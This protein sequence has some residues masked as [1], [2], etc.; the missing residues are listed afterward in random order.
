MTEEGF[1][2]TELCLSI[3]LTDISTDA[4]EAAMVSLVDAGFVK[5]ITQPSPI[6]DEGVMSVVVPGGLLLTPRG[7]GLVKSKGKDFGLLNLSF[8]ANVGD[9]HARAKPAASIGCARLH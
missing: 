1:G 6:F 5:K 4:A 7:K 8:Q 9:F 2:A 3:T